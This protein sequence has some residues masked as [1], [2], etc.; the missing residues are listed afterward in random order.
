MTG[1]FEPVTLILTRWR[2]TKIT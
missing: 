1:F 2:N